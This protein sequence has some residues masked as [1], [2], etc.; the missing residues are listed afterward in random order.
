MSTTVVNIREVRSGFDVYIGRRC[1]RASDRR[2]HADSAFC[3]PYT[4]SDRSVGN[5][6]R[7]IELFEALM[8]RRLAGGG[9][10]GL[11]Y[12]GGAVWTAE[13]WRSE[14]LKLQGKRLGCWCEPDPCHGHVLVRLIEELA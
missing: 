3:N 12:I 11:A 4:E 9:A 10:T 6:E 7:A 5:R 2:C 14:L 8:R 13:R 1:L